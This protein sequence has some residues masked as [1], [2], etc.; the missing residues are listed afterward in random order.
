VHLETATIAKRQRQQ[1]GF[2]DEIRYL[3]QR[4]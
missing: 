4:R 3:R 1:G 2:K